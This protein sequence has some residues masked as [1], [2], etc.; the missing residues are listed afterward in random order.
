MREQRMMQLKR[1]L[2]A[3]KVPT[4]GSYETINDEKKLMLMTTSTNS[5][6]IHFAH[7]DFKRCR[8]MDQHMEI[9]A[10]TYLYTRF[11]RV[12]V[13]NVPF[14]VDRMDIKVLPCVISF[15]EGKGVDRLLGFE[16]VSEGDS[17]SSSDLEAR[18]ALS[19]IAY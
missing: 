1:E 18:L 14:L 11:V 12:Y 3:K 7:K 15:I 6:V 2:D 4:F 10:K 8:I 19:S 5:M 17:F 16:G 13:E 9:L